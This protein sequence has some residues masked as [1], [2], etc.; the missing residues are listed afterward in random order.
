MSVDIENWLDQAV[1][2]RHLRANIHMERSR[3]ENGWL[4]VPV[5]ID[6]TGDA[7]DKAHIL[8][9][10]EDAW[11]DR[12]PRPEIRLLLVPAAN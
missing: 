8:Q 3:R 12:E 9:E 11:N 1:K 2:E 6:I 5:F 10:L 7:Y 4:H